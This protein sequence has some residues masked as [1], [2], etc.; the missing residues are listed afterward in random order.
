[1]DQQFSTQ[2]PASSF[3]YTGVPAYFACESAP[4]KASKES[5]FTCCRRSVGL[6]NPLNIHTI[7]QAHPLGVDSTHP[8]N[9]PLDHPLIDST[10]SSA[11]SP[12]L[13]HLLRSTFG[14]LTPHVAAPALWTPSRKAARR[15]Q[16]PWASATQPATA[17]AA[18]SE[19]GQTTQAHRSL[20]CQAGPGGWAEP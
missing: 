9:H 13:S 3:A 2:G 7:T 11:L 4:P 16:P 8:V 1:V 18:T 19:P 10:Q 15:A 14:I 12:S 6:R 17:T 5:C 20:L